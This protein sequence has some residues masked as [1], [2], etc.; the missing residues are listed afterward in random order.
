[1]FVSKS[2]LALALTTITQ[3]PSTASQVCVDQ[4]NFKHIRLNGIVNDN[5]CGWMKKKP[6]TRPAKYCL[7]DLAV[8]N[9]CPATCKEVTLNSCP[10]SDT[11]NYTFIG[12]ISGQ[13]YD[14]SW[15]TQSSDPAK[16]AKRCAR[17]CLE[18]QT[19]I[20]CAGTCSECFGSIE[21]SPLC[22][23]DPF[24]ECVSEGCEW[25]LE[26]PEYCDENVK[27]SCGQCDPIVNSDDCSPNTLLYIIEENVPIELLGNVLTFTFGTS[28]YS[29][30]LKASGKVIHLVEEC[31]ELLENDTLTITLEPITSE[32]GIL[33]KIQ[34]FV[35]KIS[36]VMPLRLPVPIG[37]VG[38][39]SSYVA[40]IDITYGGGCGSQC[41][42]GGPTPMPST[43]PTSG[44]TPTQPFPAPSRPPSPMPSP[45]PTLRPTSSP[46]DAPSMVPSVSPSE[47]PSKIPS[48]SPSMLPSLVP[49]DSPSM[50][51]SD[52]PSDSP[53]AVPSDEPSQVPSMVPSDQPSQLPSK[54]PSRSPSSI[55][56]D[57]PSQIPSKEPSRSPSGNPTESIKPSPTPTVSPIGPTPAPTRAP[58]SAPTTTCTDTIGYKFWQV[59][60]AKEQECDW[61]CR[62]TVDT[63]FEY[64]KAVYC[65]GNPDIFENCCASCSSSLGC[66]NQCCSDCESCSNLGN[67]CPEG[68][69]YDWQSCLCV[70][71]SQCTDGMY[72][73]QDSNLCEA[74]TTRSLSIPSQD[75]R[76][77]GSWFYSTA[78]CCNESE[79]D[80]WAL[81][82]VEDTAVDDDGWVKLTPG[83]CYGKAWI[84]PDCEGMTCG[85]GFYKASVGPTTVICKTPNQ[86][87]WPFTNWRWSGSA[88]KDG[89]ALSP[90][91]RNAKV[92]NNTPPGY[93][94]TYP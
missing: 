76:N 10:R 59:N 61:L 11:P 92:G 27:A 31:I 69:S 30:F 38:A 6:G 42:N 84:G 33:E 19:A 64:R 63:K 57:Q 94:Y 80:E 22:V 9:S 3:I 53:S 72:S 55:P 18:G 54:E 89:S 16:T 44:P 70:P 74:D 15:I 43:M 14:C 36:T 51:P 79:N 68:E 1:M 29:I 86:D 58:T 5:F 52:V 83:Q 12:E 8:F 87:C 88:G 13:T 90:K 25:F 21:S 78:R 73:Q 71:Q 35:E 81:K 62:N 23:A 91:Q 17:Y 50:V 77:L 82:A 20:N 49:S 65:D 37:G 48:D 4:S 60:G 32:R 56:S 67:S 45:F 34:W 41:N 47:S 7:D 93:T 46:S 40:D 26:N 85:G 66:G 2:T 24:G 39:S 75:I 28:S